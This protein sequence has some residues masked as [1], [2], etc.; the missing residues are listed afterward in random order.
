VKSNFFVIRIFLVHVW[1]DETFI[2]VILCFKFVSDQCGAMAKAI[3]IVLSG[4]R[5]RW[6]RWHVLKSAK[7]RLGNV[8]SKHKKFKDEFRSLITDEVDIVKFESAWDLLLKRYRLTKNKFLKRLFKYR[9][10]WAKPYFMDVF[11]AG[12]TST[13]RSESGNH[14]LKRFIQR[15]APMHLFVRKFNEL[16]ADRNEQ[17]S[18]ED[19]CTNQ[20]WTY[21]RDHV[22]F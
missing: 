21:I 10:K 18:R 15:A 16:Q 3:R 17:E 22:Y 7:E 6:C 1:F 9:E 19:H 4:S 5:H 14:M 8:Y 2:L 13:Q 20:V 12:M 11:C